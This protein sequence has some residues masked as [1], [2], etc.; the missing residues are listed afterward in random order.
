MRYFAVTTDYIAW[1][2]LQGHLI[3]LHVT[4]KKHLI[5][6][7]GKLGRHMIMSHEILGRNIWLC[8]M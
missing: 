7:N 6:L 2:A 5:I 8:F 4:S 1:Y 3:V